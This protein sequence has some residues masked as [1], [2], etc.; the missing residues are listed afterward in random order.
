ML[1]EQYKEY[2]NEIPMNTIRTWGSLLMKN[3]PWEYVGWSGEAKE[4][5]R[6][7]AAYPDFEGE[8]VKIWEALNYSF[9]EDGFN[10][11]PERI[12][13][14]LFAHG[15]SSWL[16]KDCES[17]SAWTAI[18]YLNDYWDPNWHGGTVLMEKGEALKY[19]NPTPGKFILFKSNLLHGPVPVSREAVFPRF[20]LTFQCDNNGKTENTF[21][22]RG[23]TSKL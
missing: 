20:G 9:Q 8:I 2:K 21:T 7:W 1:N 6:H 17:D 3:L 15:D 10:L 11:S 13:A 4:P 5:Y 18:L 23:S 12:I 16:H 14:N 19:F 22:V